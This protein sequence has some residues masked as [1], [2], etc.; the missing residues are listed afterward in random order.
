MINRDETYMNYPR[1]IVEIESELANE[2]EWDL[3]GVQSVL[4]L[5]TVFDERHYCV[6]GVKGNAGG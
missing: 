3:L 5:Q 6:K 2:A 4:N 1:N